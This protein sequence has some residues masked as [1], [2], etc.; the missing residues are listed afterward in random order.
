MAA[1]PRQWM[2]SFPL[3]LRK[4]K[5]VVVAIESL[6]ENTTGPTVTIVVNLADGDY[7]ATSVSVPDGIL[8]EI[9]G[10]G[11]VTMNGGSPSLT[12]NSGNVIVTGVTFVNDTDAPTILVNGGSLS[13]A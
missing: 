3:R 1:P 11:G 2:L 5:T 9:H 7:D 4:C 13:I 8:L 6:G 12:I 10:T